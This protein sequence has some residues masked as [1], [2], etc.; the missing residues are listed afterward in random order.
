MAFPM[1]LFQILFVIGF[2][3]TAFYFFSL[4]RLFNLLKEKYPDKF[5][6]LGEPS[7]WW[8][9][10]PGNGIRVLR[11]ISS[12]DPIFSTDKELL[13]TRNFASFLLYA[14]MAILILLLVL[15]SLSFFGSY[16]EFG[17]G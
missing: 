4:R 2:I 11:F 10:S 1:K 14:G 6:E 7:L 8:N 5:K 9:N 16:R 13:T 3:N 12:K 17:G 15:F